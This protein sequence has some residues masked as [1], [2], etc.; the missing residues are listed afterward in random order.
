MVK[1]VLNLAGIDTAKYT[2]HSTCSASMSA[3]KTMDIAIDIIMESAGWT[4]ES[5]F[6]K[7]YKKPITSK[8]N[9]SSC[10]LQK[11]QNTQPN[12][13]TLYIMF[14][15]IYGSNHSNLLCPFTACCIPFT[16]VPL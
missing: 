10:L 1:T 16:L 7:F 14:Y 4:Q 6:V 8:N 2:A 5:T 3:A 15:C 11:C 12:Y 13:V 9:F